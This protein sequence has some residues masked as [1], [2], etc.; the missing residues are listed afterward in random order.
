[1]VRTSQKTLYA[2]DLNL[3]MLAGLP[4]TPQTNTTLN[5]KFGIN[6]HLTLPEDKYP[7]MKYYCIGVGGTSPIQGDGAYISCEH[8]P[9]DAALFT[10]VPFVM[11]SVRNDL[12]Q[13]QRADYRMRV[14]QTVA[15]VQYACYYLKVFPD[16]NLPDYFNTINTVTPEDESKLPYSTIS[17]FDTNVPEILTPTPRIRNIDVTKISTVSKV[18]RIGRVTLEFTETDLKEIRNSMSILGY[19]Y[20]TIKEVGLCSGY[21]ISTDIGKEVICSQILF[22]IGIEMSLTIKLNTEASIKRIIELGGEEPLVR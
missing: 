3:H 13:A 6:T 15:G 16:M 21:D 8:S 12:T 17:V 11:R 10:H 5:E 18:T 7:T 4:Y 14:L 2:T 9:L 22:H 20:S 19:D 1:M